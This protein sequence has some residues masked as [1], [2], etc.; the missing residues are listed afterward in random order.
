MN[1]QTEQLLGT[2]EVI[3]ETRIEFW[4]PNTDIAYLVPF[5]WDVT[6]KG[7]FNF[8]NFGLDERWITGTDIEVAIEG[9]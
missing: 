3:T 1:P 7:E 9:W 2:L 5:V 4:L 8:I 6:Q